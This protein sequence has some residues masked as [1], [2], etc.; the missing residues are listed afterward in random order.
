MCG[1]IAPF[2][3]SG[4]TDDTGSL[5]TEAETRQG[6]YCSLNCNLLFSFRGKMNCASL[7]VVRRTRPF[8][9][10]PSGNPMEI[11]GVVVLTSGSGDRPPH[12]LQFQGCVHP[13]WSDRSGVAETRSHCLS[14]PISVGDSGLFSP[15]Q[16]H[17]A[18]LRRSCFPLSIVID[19]FLFATEFH[20]FNN[21]IHLICSVDAM[22]Y[23]IT[24]PMCSDN[25]SQC[26]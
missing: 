2:C 9:P 4:D 15:A 17:V 23:R 1:R 7:G 20:R 22:L 21:Q 25:S 24:P 3:V 16:K 13:D 5:Q 10:P 8:N 14:P 12:S 26:S 6:L 19:S 18:I 11:M